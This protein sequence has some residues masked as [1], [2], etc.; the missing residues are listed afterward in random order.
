M[1]TILN[2]LHLFITLLLVLIS[3]SFYNKIRT[4]EEEFGYMIDVQRTIILNA[5]A[6]KELRIEENSHRDRVPRSSSDPL[7]AAPTEF[8]L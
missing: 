8:E 4:L 2:G 7:S 1:K 6:E 3:F 5:L